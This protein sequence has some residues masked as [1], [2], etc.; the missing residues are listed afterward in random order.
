MTISPS[1]PS[2][3]KASDDGMKR[4]DFWIA[5]ATVIVNVH[6]AGR[7]GELVGVAMK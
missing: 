6:M 1:A 7:L 2:A 5:S 3:P 4:V